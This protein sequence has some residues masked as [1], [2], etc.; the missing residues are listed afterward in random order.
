MTLTSLARRCTPGRRGNV[1]R[2]RSMDNQQSLE[3]IRGYFDELFGKRNLDALEL[4]LDK[5]HYDDDIGDSSVDHIQNSREYLSALFREKPTIGVE[6]KDAMTQ[7]D[8]ITAF[9]EWFTCENNVRQT[10][11][12]GVGIF[13]LKDGK[14]LK[15]HNYLYY[16]K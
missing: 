2:R 8:V 16:E 6:V 15:R 5:N 4:Y 14:I 10:L 11:M 3:F 7:D 1:E 13:V 12:K 9:L